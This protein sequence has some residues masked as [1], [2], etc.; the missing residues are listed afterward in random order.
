MNLNEQI[1]RMKSI[2]GVVD[3]AA[4]T[5]NDLPP[6]TGLYYRSNINIGDQ[7]V[8]Y[9]ASEDKLYGGINIHKTEEDPN[10]YMVSRV[11][12]NQ[13]YGPLL[14]DMMLSYVYPKPLIPD[15]Y[16]ISNDAI[17]VWRFYFD[18]RN[19]IK[20]EPIDIDD[21]LYSTIYPYEHEMPR[22]ELKWLLNQ[23]E[24]RETK[25]ELDIYNSK[26]IGKPLDIEHLLNN[27][28]QQLK[29]KKANL[30]SLI[31]RSGKHFDLSKGNSS[32]HDI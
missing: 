15:R 6:D 28:N 17:K 23:P 29:L 19:D 22:E 13:G 3:E 4:K 11:S 1:H 30:T 31:G 32:D 9:S 21:E 14:Y 26:Y 25:H 5:T 7:F 2:M 18:N 16:N 10:V 20:K 27:A 12:A 24:Y 8:L